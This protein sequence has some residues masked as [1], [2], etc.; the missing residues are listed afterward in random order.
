MSK[1]ARFARLVRLFRILRMAK[2]FRLYKDRKRMERAGEAV[3]KLNENVSRLVIFGLVIV[4]INHLL[5]CLWIL[6]TKFNVVDNWIMSYQTK[7]LESRT[8]F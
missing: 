3:V 4:F 6:T 5:A 2:L 8:N 7:D 1:F